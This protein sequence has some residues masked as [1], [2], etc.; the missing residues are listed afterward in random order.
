MN[1]DSAFVIGTTHSVCQDYVVAG[2]S[3]TASPYI[4]LSDGCSS[5]R[6]TDVGSRL[7]VK[8]AESILNQAHQ[9]DVELVHVEAARLALEHAALLG[10]APQSVD[11]TLLTAH[12][13]GG[14]VIT[15]CSGDGVI[16]AQTNSGIIEAYSIS[17]A[18]GY[19][20]YPAY[21]HQPHRLT[22]LEIA[23]PVKEI[24]Y[25]RG[26]LQQPRLQLHDTW[27]SNLAT[28]VFPFSSDTYQ[29]VVL[30][31]DGVHSFASTQD[32]ASSKHARTVQ[33]ESFAQ[34]LVSFKNVRGAF[35]TRR[36]N[37]F[38]KDCDI[39]GRKHSDDLSIGAIY[40]GG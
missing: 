1:A 14:E 32:S 8:S 22:C 29:F 39:T 12:F 35:A 27:R 26:N 40:L 33:F 19:P 4:I 31:S 10:L 30:L 25:F 17:Y 5:S 6:D 20:R 38:L 15:A 7:L 11:A 21:S 16:L 3:A 34:E 36:L 13:S 23:D 37:R 9:K 24:R 2:N 18:S 28:E